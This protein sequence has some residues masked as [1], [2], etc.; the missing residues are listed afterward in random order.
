MLSNKKYVP[1][2]FVIESSTEHHDIFKHLL[3]ALFQLI[4]KPEMII[5]SG[6]KENKIIAYA[7]LVAHVAFLKTV[8]APPFNTVYNINFLGQTFVIKETPFD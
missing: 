6:Y 4:R 5:A 8:P 1:V 3:M 2:A 7:E